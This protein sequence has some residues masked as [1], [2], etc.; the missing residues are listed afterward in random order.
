MPLHRDRKYC[1]LHPAAKKGDHHTVRSILDSAPDS[2]ARTLLLEATD[3]HGKTP[4]LRA[5][6]YGHH[7]VVTMLL[8]AGANLRAIDSSKRTCLHLAV[9]NGHVEVTKALL[10]RSAVPLLEQVDA[11]GKRPL[12]LHPTS[13]QADIQRLL[14]QTNALWTRHR[15]DDLL[16]D[17]PL[18][19]LTM[20]S[21][22][23]SMAREHRL[24][25]TWGG[26]VGGSLNRF[27]S[28]ASSGQPLLPCVPYAQVRW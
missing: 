20:S 12:D 7:N 10:R 6:K 19:P 2:H 14:H 5:S 23:R 27:L 15:N 17:L 26:A 24:S 1:K 28:P 11:S 21:H 9:A 16:D 22:R 4:L 8:R 3:R 25:S 18:A 13:H